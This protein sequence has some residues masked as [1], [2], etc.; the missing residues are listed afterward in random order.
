MFMKLGLIFLLTATGEKDQEIARIDRQIEELKDLQERYRYSAEKN[1]NNAMRWQ[2]QS[3]NYLNAR[4][5]WD[6]VAQDKQKI[7][8]IQLQIDDLKMRQAKLLEENGK[9]SDS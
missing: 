1:T 6:K 8:E 3:E 5:A 2:F 4:R 7:S 9:G